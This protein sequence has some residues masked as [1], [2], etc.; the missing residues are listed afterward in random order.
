M[1]SPGFFHLANLVPLEEDE[2][3]ESSLG[4]S[5]DVV[6]VVVVNFVSAS[7]DDVPAP[8]VAG[9]EVGSG[10]EALITISPLQHSKMDNGY[11]RTI[12]YYFVIH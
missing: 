9:A 8:V 6:Y 10:G 5:N 1:I 7:D 3:T 2:E 4:F 12:E 11:Y